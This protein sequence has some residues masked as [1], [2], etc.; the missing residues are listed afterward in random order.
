MLEHDSSPDRVFKAHDAAVQLEE[1]LPRYTLPPRFIFDTRISL[2]TSAKLDRSRLRQLAAHTQETKV[3][4]SNNKSDRPLTV[5]EHQMQ[6]LF[7]EVLGLQVSDILV[8]SDLFPKRRPFHQG[9]AI[10][11][12]SPSRKLSDNRGKNL[13]LYYPG[14]ACEDVAAA[15]RFV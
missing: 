1:R 8:E 5:A 14:A 15:Q 12:S 7:A 9:Y 13:A 10:G 4:N 11:I 3:G 2:T 6:T